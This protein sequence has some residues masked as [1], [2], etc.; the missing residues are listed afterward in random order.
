LRTDAEPQKSLKFQ[1]N[2]APIK[3][4][5]GCATHS[6]KLAICMRVHLIQQQLANQ[7]RRRLIDWWAHL[8]RSFSFCFDRDAA[9]TAAAESNDFYLLQSSL[10]N[11]LI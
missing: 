3:T 6:Q 5:K 2:A 1:L 7:S 4:T 8:V 11:D 9:A 10:H